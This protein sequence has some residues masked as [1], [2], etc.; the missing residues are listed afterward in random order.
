MSYKAVKRY[1]N[2]RDGRIKENKLSQ[3]ADMLPKRH[4]TMREFKASFGDVNHYTFEFQGYFIVIDLKYAF[5]HFNNNT[6]LQK[7]EHLNGTL[8]ETLTNPLI[9]VKSK[10]ED[11]QTLTFYKPFKNEQGLHHMLMFKAFK[12]ENGKYYF[13]TIYRA[14][15]L[16]KVS[17]VIKTL[18]LNTVYFK[19]EDTEGN[20]S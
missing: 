1:I 20:G 4:R 6:Y 9:V 19:Y 3:D 11:E 14:D 12:K 15:T 17:K 5:N 2:P 8:L 10:Y 16:D 13:K 18:D 7:R